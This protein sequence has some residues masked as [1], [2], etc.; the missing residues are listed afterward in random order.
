MVAVVPPDHLEVNLRSPLNLVATSFGV[1]HGVVAFDSD[2][3]RPYKATPGG[4]DIVYQGSIYRSV[5]NASCFV[6]LGYSQAFLS[7]SAT[8]GEPME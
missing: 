2:R 6:V 1:T 8:E 7:R 3:L 5:E 4:F